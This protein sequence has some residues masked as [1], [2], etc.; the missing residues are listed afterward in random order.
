MPVI[1]ALACYSHAWPQYSSQPLLILPD[2]S[3][4][5]MGALFEDVL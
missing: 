2:L 5:G 1:T 4:V 3:F